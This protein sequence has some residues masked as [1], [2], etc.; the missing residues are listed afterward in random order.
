MVSKLNFAIFLEPEFS[1][2]FEF[3]TMDVLGKAATILLD[4]FKKH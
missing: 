2:N 4:N 1:E 3:L